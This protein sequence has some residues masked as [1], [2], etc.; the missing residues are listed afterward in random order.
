[1]T[2]IGRNS[3]EEEQPMEVKRPPFY[4]EQP[5]HRR[6]HH[7]YL[8]GMIGPPE[9]YIDFI[10]VL[11]AAPPDDVIHLHLNTS[12]GRLDTGV[13]I[14]NAIK[15]SSCAVICSLEAEAHSLGTLIFLACDEWIVHE[16]CTMMFHQYSGGTFGKGNEQ[17]AQVNANNEWFASLAKDLYVPF[18]SEE[19]VNMILQGQDL[20]MLTPEIRKRLDKMVKTIEKERKAKEKAEAATIK[21]SS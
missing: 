15:S 13:Q 5:L 11:R 7:L 12:G 6:I 3:E 18:L 19:E 21:K 10:H 17:A 2:I 16:N 4:F 20:W 14:I 9:A 1:M 8:S